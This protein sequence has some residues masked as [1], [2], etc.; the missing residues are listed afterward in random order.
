VLR[1]R[2]I[3]IE[4]VRRIQ[5]LELAFDER[6]TVICGTN[7]IGKS[8]VLDSISALMSFSHVNY[9][10]FPLSGS[11]E[12]K[13]FAKLI[14]NDAEI[15]RALTLTVV[16]GVP[17][18]QP[19][20]VR[21]SSQYPEWNR[22]IVAFRGF[23]DIAYQ[24]LGSLTPDQN[25]TD[26]IAATEML[27]GPNLQSVKGWFARRLALIQYLETK[28][29]LLA[30]LDLAKGIF[31]RLDPSVSYHS[32][33]P[34]TFDINVKSNISI[35]PFEYLSSGFKAV[36]LLILRLIQSIEER[37]QNDP[38]HAGNFSGVILIDEIDVHLHPSWQRKV[39]SI[40]KET[41]P[42]A[43][44]IVTTHSPFVVQNAE[45]NEVIALEEVGEPGIL[46]RR[47][48]L[49]T[50]YGFRG[51]TVEEILTEVMALESTTTDELIVAK[52]D[53][54]RALDSSDQVGATKALKHLLQLLHPQSELRDLLR[55]QLSSVGG[56][57]ESLESL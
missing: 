56:A 53:F 27:S 50:P 16:S 42:E 18:L 25:V 24:P 17:R 38:I 28:P 30:D 32:F 37:F 51:W 57:S 48:L 44:F 29:H 12:G 4:N 3:A 35:I 26:S 52:Q 6:S 40:L 47:E 33:N 5:K 43:Q 45:P 7:G 46:Q 49:R 34:Q 9:P 55:V 11:K 23:R 14:F 21:A 15:Q 10:L 13:L 54:T 20:H 31:S 41:F 22:E 39:L 19:D 8:T 1:I 2:S 36:Y